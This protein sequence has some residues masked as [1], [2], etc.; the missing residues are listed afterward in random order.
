MH[1]R[2]QLKRIEAAARHNDGAVASQEASIEARI[3]AAVRHAERACGRISIPA[4]NNDAMMR[5]AVVE[6]IAMERSST[7]R[8][9]VVELGSVLHKDHITNI[10]SK[11]VFYAALKSERRFLSTCTHVSKP[12]TFPCHEH[13]RICGLMPV[14]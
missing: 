1:G 12:K 6:T 7:E 2:L 9:A 3:E 5:Q 8:M 13:P 11:V 14:S 10:L 4:R